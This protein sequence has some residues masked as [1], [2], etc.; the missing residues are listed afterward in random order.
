M[1]WTHRSSLSRLPQPTTRRAAWRWSARVC[2]GISGLVSTP[3]L[4]QAVIK[5][6]G[7]H[8]EYHFEA[9]PHLAIGISRNSGIGPGFRGTIELV[10]N[11]F[12]STINNTVGVGFG[13]D[14]LLNDVVLLPVV[15]QW[16]FWILRELS[17]FGEPGLAIATEGDRVRPVI[18]A[19]ARFHFTQHT[20]F[21][22]RVG[23]PV[24]TIGVSLLL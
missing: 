11:G 17:V 1:H 10:D 19:G 5:Q 23:P 22:V 7:A 16:N 20:T 15:M 9:E 12:V 13:A 14:I 8:P 21:T 4:A 6:P 3:A 18:E 2:V 24:V